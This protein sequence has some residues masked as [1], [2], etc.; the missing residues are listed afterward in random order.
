VPD[1]PIDRTA[2]SLAYH[3][4]VIVALSASRQTEIL[5]K[6]QE[7]WQSNEF[8]AAYVLIQESGDVLASNPMFVDVDQDFYWTFIQ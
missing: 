2:I 1:H 5:A 8:R 7:F 6:F 4:A 3:D